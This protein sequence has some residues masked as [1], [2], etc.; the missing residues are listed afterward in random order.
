MQLK[1]RRSVGM[2][3]WIHTPLVLEIIIR[4]KHADRRATHQTKTDSPVQVKR[5]SSLPFETQDS[6]IYEDQMPS[7]A[8]MMM[9]FIDDVAPILKVKKEQE[10]IVDH[11]IFYDSTEEELALALLL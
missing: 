6:V 7:K 3:T 8:E 1:L 4:G 11:N 9:T 10:P 5:M 2:M